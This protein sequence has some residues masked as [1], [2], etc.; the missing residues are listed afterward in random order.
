MVKNAY[1]CYCEAVK[2]EIKNDF[3]YFFTRR[4][5]HHYLIKIY[6]SDLAL[7]VN[8]K[9]MTIMIM[10]MLYDV[11]KTHSSYAKLWHALMNTVSG[12]LT[13]TE[14]EIIAPIYYNVVYKK[15]KFD[16]VYST[17]RL[18]DETLDI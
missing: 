14:G 10:I 3:P 16:T 18:S 15:H 7:K 8:V 12:I 2:V 5:M 1:S 4:K 11:I 13:Q 6:I 17:Y 9:R